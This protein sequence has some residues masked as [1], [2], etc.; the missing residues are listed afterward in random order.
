MGLYRI[1]Q[2]MW[3]EGVDSLWLFIYIYDM[4]VALVRHQHMHDASMENLQFLSP[5][6]RSY[7][8]SC[9]HLHWTIGTCC[10]LQHYVLSRQKSLGW[11]S[12]SKHLW[13]PLNPYCFMIAASKDPISRNGCGLPLGDLCFVTFGASDGMGCGWM[14]MLRSFLGKPYKTTTSNKA[15]VVQ[16]L[17]WICS[18]CH[19]YGFVT[20]IHMSCCCLI[21]LTVFYDMYNCDTLEIWIAGTKL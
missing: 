6:L 21:W 9:S 14:W 4:I 15:F 2:F 13:S 17:S 1:N 12:E 10:Q 11:P 18:S 5:T 16:R 7:F 8:K 19:V 20:R 3:T